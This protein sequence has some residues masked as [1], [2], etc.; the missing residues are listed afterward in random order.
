MLEHVKT[1]IADVLEQTIRAVELRDTLS[2]KKLSNYTIHNASIY[3][4]DCSISIAIIIYSLS[5]IIE[6]HRY[7][8]TET[9]AQV[10]EDFI[11][12]LQKASNLLK[13]NNYSGYHAI[14]KQIFRRI[15][16]VDS[17]IALYVEEVIEKS[18]IN[19][20]SRIYEHG[21]SMAQVAAILGISEWELMNY[22]GKTQI[23]DAEKGITNVK[24]RLK[25]A[26]A[27]FNLK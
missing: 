5:K 12:K 4:D 7:A 26:R 19:K 20:G 14:I 2:L 9:W 24:S 17:E 10:Y 16:K 8:E 25:F 1:T 23:I 18:K 15:S 6:R 13:K 11:E 27:L 22:V 21:I 3:Q